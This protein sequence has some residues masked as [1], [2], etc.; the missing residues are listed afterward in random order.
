MMM[1][2]K[3]EKKKSMFVVRQ[4]TAKYCSGKPERAVTEHGAVGSQ[5]TRVINTHGCC[6]EHK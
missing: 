3:L 6:D 5:H 1:D 2:G 4:K